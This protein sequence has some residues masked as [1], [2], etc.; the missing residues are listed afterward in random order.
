[1]E[2]GGQF[3]PLGRKR[4]QRVSKSPKK[5]IVEQKMSSNRYVKKE[6]KSEN[7]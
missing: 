7:K 6:N 4:R 1:M 5:I 3:D 2:R